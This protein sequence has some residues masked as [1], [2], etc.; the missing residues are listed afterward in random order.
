MALVDWG[1]H[2]VVTQP[3]L[4]TVLEIPWV[5]EQGAPSIKC[6]M[7]Y[8][9]EGLMIDDS[10]MKYILEALEEV[11]GMLLVHA[12]DHEIIG[13]RVPAMINSGQVAAIYHARSRPVSAENN[14]IQRCIQMVEEIGGNLFVL[15]LASADGINMIKAAQKK[16]LNIFA[17]TCTH[18]LLFTEEVLERPDGIKWICSP[19][20]RDKYN[21]DQL[22]KGLKDN[23]ISLVTSND[24][25]FSWET[26]LYG[27]DRFDL[28]PSGL[29]GIEPRLNL[30][31]SEGVAK[32]RLTLSRWVELI[33]TAPANFFGLAPRK[34]SLNLL[35]DADIVL[36]DPEEEWVMNRESLH[37][38]ADWSA[39]ENL[40][41]K[42][43]IKKV[44]SRGELIIDG[45][46][47]LAEKG[48]GRY[49]HRSPRHR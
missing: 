15:H 22:W 21:Q 3:T 12:E 13:T 36:F 34:G 46:R 16:K 14:A 30:L 28:C 37:M 49:L 42:G 5:V 8:R 1:V 47:C 41:I 27:K 17:E 31:Y 20:L 35:S 45:D 43:K 11:G 32:G 10:D 2:P 6:Y 4:D 18:Y 44:F 39:Y 48:R 7:T 24:I 29:P 26:K 25:A 19:P 40:K 23:T 33:S 9:E 38:A